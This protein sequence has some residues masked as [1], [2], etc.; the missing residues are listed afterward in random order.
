MGAQQVDE[1]V[2]RELGQGR[3]VP[4][5]S[6]RWSAASPDWVAWAATKR[7]RQGV[8]SRRPVSQG[9]KRQLDLAV[10]HGAR[11]PSR[12][13]VCSTASTSAASL[14]AHTPRASPGL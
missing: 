9:V 5:A 4:G 12:C 13:S 6:R 14:C 1:L 11:S 3:R 10:T 7:S 2:W 8:I